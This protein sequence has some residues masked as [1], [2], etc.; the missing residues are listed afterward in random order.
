[1]KI[2][3]LIILSFCTTGNASCQ[4]KVSVE[5]PVDKSGNFVRLYNI[6]K[7]YDKI[8]GLPSLE[9]GYDSFQLRVWCNY[10]NLKKTHLIVISN[11][12]GKWDGTLY[13]LLIDSKS[14]TSYFLEKADKKQITP[15]SGWGQLISKMN[16][17]KIPTL[18]SYEY[19]PGYGIGVDGEFYMVE[20][21]TQNKYRFYDYY[22]PRNEAK[23][24]KEAEVL[25]EFLEILEKEFSFHRHEI[26]E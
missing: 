3:V 11:K 14:D 12:A 5:I 25:E 9:N 2:L 8:L 18:L 23:D 24:Y 22:D 21:A 7:K 1:M 6:K 16:E 26:L 19:L 17:L 10:G 13:R 20:V 15:R 4:R